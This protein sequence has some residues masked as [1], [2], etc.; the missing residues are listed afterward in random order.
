MKII[1]KEAVYNLG[2]SGDIVDVKNGYGR[3]YLIPQ[4]KA[5]FATPGAVE[6][7]ERAQKEMEERL[8][9]SEK[10][11]QSIADKLE[12]INLTFSVKTNE[13]GKIFGTITTT[14]IAEAL[15]EKGIE[16]DRRK[17]EIDGDVKSL[18]EYKATVS[19]YGDIKGYIKFWVVKSE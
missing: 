18:G 11:A 16:L 3:N 19:L 8:A 12:S 10:Q 15:S 2:E 7:V 13:E 6:A 4:G 1:L 5:V 9:L 14:Q 17:I